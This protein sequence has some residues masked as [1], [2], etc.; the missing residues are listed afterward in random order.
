MFALQEAALHELAPQ[1]REVTLRQNLLRDAVKAATQVGNAVT[2]MSWW[3]ELHI[4]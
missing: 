1:V 2:T 4:V 3:Q